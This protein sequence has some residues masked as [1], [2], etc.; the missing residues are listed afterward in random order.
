MKAIASSYQLRVGVSG[1][2]KRLLWLGKRY[3][4]VAFV[5]SEMGMGL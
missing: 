3:N 2:Y 4:W 1:Y 5:Q